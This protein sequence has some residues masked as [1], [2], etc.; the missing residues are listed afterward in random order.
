MTFLELT[1]KK[2]GFISLGCDKNRVDLEKMIYSFKSAGFEITPIYEEANII[3]INTCSFILDARK[4][5]IN[6]I[7]ETIPLKNLNLEKLVVTGCLNNMKY[8]DLSTSLPEV[9]LF[10]KVED[11]FKIVKLV[12]DL[13]NVKFDSTTKNKSLDRILTTPKHYAYLK[14]A[15]GCDNFCTYCTIPYIRG[16]FKS[17][18][19]E[20]I[21]SEAKDLVRLGTKEIILVAQDV[22]KYGTDL[23]GK[24]QL[25]EL[26]KELEKINDLKWIRLLYCYP[27]LIDDRLIN[28]I[29]RNKKVCHYIDIP[30]QHVSSPVLKKMNRR[31]NNEQ[32]CKIIES[33][34]NK[35]PD[36]A[37]RTTFILGFPNETEE[38][39]NTLCN[40]VQ[41][42]KLDNVGFFKYSREDGTPASKFPNQ[43]PAKIKSERLKVLSNLQYLTVKE[44]HNKLLGK[45]IEVVVDEIIDNWA[46][47]HS[48]KLCPTVDPVVF[49]PSDGVKV[50]GFYKVKLVKIK[51]YDFIG[52][53]LWKWIYLI[54]LL[55][56]ELL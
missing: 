11:N 50:G 48:E 25:V 32:I 40:F 37:I 1:K 47:C 36:I 42:Y 3:I 24:P 51:K 52:E 8:D 18:P 17:E 39:F 30:L 56:Q 46:V 10:V 28:E 31:T 49:I 55:L 20:K 38:D 45:E 12:A 26:L 43:I 2:V 5:S 16:R 29:A 13:Y 19:I 22:T 54:N 15:D 44:K 6:T 7:L 33:L 34:K 41:K 9:D 23:Y 21:V 53:K 14:I 35:I 4:E 27:D